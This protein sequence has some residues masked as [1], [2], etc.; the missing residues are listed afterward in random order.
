MNFEEG[1][2]A[3]LKRAGAATSVSSIGF[4]ET[5]A[6]AR[7]ERR[8][9]M[10]AV[11]GAAAA[12]MAGGVVGAT[13][14]TQGPPEPAPQDPVAVITESPSPSV[15][16]TP[17]P[18]QSP[19]SSPTPTPTPSLTSAATPTPTPTPTPTVTEGPG[20]EGQSL[21]SAIPTVRAWIKAIARGDSEAAWAM[22]SEGAKQR[23][24]SIDEFQALSTEL[25][26]GLGA[27]AS[28][29]DVRYLLSNVESSEREAAVVV[30]LVGEVMQEGTT[31]TRAQAVPVVV[32][33]SVA[34]IDQSFEGAYYITPAAPSESSGEGG[35]IVR[36]RGRFTAYVT[37]SKGIEEV[38][39]AV[40]GDDVNML[41]ATEVIDRQKLLASVE[42]IN[43]LEPGMHVLTIAATDV[44]GRITPKALLFE[45]R[46]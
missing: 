17:T 21:A 5:L 13:V 6:R 2:R 22:M 28:S 3:S 9:Y 26:E 19:E 44:T 1:L 43:P 18:S 14:L 42:L 27:W 15:T 16:E 35:N 39:F 41:A 38:V 12:L 37:P 36:P 25:Q 30:T 20:E 32:V 4:E 11:A 23:I 46:G 34:Y 7:R 45:V 24:G 31:V 29:P 10:V 40:D 8:I 33:N